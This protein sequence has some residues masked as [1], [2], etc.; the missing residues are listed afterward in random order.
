MR[1]SC[2]SQL[3]HARCPASIT[4]VTSNP[5]QVDGRWCTFAMSCGAHGLQ[6]SIFTL[7]AL[8]VITDAHGFIFIF[9]AINHNVLQC[10]VI[11][12]GVERSTCVY[13]C[14]GMM[15]NGN[16]SDWRKRAFVSNK[17]VACF[18][19][20]DSCWTHTHTPTNYYSE[21]VYQFYLMESPRQTFPFIGLPQHRIDNN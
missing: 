8:S 5:F 2:A 12:I 1:I 20:L 18:N 15:I 16:R 21:I 11:R 3:F 10:V 17:C 14:N 9:N 19:N 4:T 7:F 13:L 6:T